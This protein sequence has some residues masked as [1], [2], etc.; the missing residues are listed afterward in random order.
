MTPPTAEEER[1]QHCLVCSRSHEEHRIAEREDVIHHEFS[2]LGEVKMHDAKRRPAKTDSRPAPGG[3]PILRFVLVDSG[4]ITAE[5]LAE[6][7]AI[8]R[9]TGLLISEQ[10]RL[11]E[12]TE[13]PNHEQG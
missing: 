13:L 10:P 1:T 9:A 12:D 11:I 2:W 6:A 7:E 3:D 8:L 4:V 5:Q